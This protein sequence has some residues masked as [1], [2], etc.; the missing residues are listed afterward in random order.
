[1]SFLS[2]LIINDD[3]TTFIHDNFNGKKPFVVHG[4]INRFSSF[5]VIE[6]LCD[7]SKIASTYTERVSMIHPK[8]SSLDVANGSESLP[9]LDKGYTVYFRDIHKQFPEIRSMISELTQEL[10]MPGNDFSAE[11]FTSKGLSGAQMHSDYHLNFSLQLSGTKDWYFARNDSITNQTSICLAG[12]KKQVDPNQL[13]YAHGPFPEAMPG[14]VEKVTL[15]PGS[16]IYV[17]RGWWHTT[18]STGDCVS[19]NF[20]TRGPHWAR[21]F[22]KA[23][24]NELLKD[25][26]W[27]EYPYGSTSSN[28]PDRMRAL[29]EFAS[30]ISKFKNEFLEEMTSK[31]LA[32]KYLDDYTNLK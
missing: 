27:R 18:Q 14:T 32:E 5:P 8:E 4:E 1:M 9:Y 12:D 11:I 28:P 25:E 26:Q 15:K 13:K 30:L 17:P 21:I 7:V 10:G 24:E 19:I 6:S 29:A 20:I 3:T 22:T 2:T 16:L 31:N 23:L